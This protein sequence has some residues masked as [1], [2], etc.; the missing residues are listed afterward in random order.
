M[1]A[2]LNFLKDFEPVAYFVLA[3]VSV[4]F[5]IR[6]GATQLRLEKTLF[7][8]EQGLL[9]KERNMAFGMLL[10]L[11]LTAAGVYLSTHVLLPEVQHAEA[12]RL[13][14]D[15]SKPTAVPTP[16]PYVL[17]GVDV[18]GCANPHATILSPKPGDTV[19]GRWDIR[20]TAD[21]PGFA[22]YRIELGNSDLGDVWMTLFTG[23]ETVQSELAY[24][25]DSSTMPP[26]VYQLRLVVVLRDGDSPRPCVVPVQVLSP[27][28]M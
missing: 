26:G 27:P 16:T 8:L 23:N 4:R 18:S 21:P 19:Q 24:T 3:V 1:L 11:G 17:F 5:F 25:W 6:I 9:R 12:N 7:E 2:L 15:P 10:L 13:A 28:L 20:L 14:A 22:F